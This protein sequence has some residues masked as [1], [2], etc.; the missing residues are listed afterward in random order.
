MS[1]RKPLIEA[2]CHIFKYPANDV[3]GLFV[4]TNSNPDTI[5]GCVPL[6][7]SS[8]VTVPVMRTSMSLFE[9]I[10]DRVVVGIYCASAVDGNIPPCVEWLQSQIL[11]TTNKCP[12]IFRFDS[13]R[14]RNGSLPFLVAGGIESLVQE[15]LALDS[16]D[17]EMIRGIFQ[18]RN[19]ISEL[20]DYEDHMNDPMT[21]WLRCL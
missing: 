15:S 19:Y 11:K 14:F 9:Q 3:C 10:E 12:P 21:D 1:A 5:C 17:L 20:N 6:F 4:G 13:E 18:T 8:C 16:A 2:I 7:H